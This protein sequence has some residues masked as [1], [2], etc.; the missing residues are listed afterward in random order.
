[1]LLLGRGALHRG[2]AEECRATGCREGETIVAGSGVLLP[3]LEGR[4]RGSGIRIA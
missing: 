1:M 3:L 4:G 2:E